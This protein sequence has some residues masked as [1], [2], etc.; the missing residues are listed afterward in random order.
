MELFSGKKV[1]SHVASACECRAADSAIQTAATE[2]A[3]IVI[4]RCNVVYLR[5]VIGRS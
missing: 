5:N 1:A 3:A 4:N 2:N